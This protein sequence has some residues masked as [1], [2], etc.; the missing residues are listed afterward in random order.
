MKR[1]YNNR[2][3]NER[4]GDL[5]EKKKEKKADCSKLKKVMNESCVAA[6]DA[7]QFL[8][9]MIDKNKRGLGIKLCCPIQ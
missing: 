7:L 6:V 1:E 4:R 8:D 5:K 2:R 3:I 9:T